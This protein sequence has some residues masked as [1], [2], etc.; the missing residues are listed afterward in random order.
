M[1]FV[2]E[3]KARTAQLMI[4]KDRVSASLKN[5][6]EVMNAD[7]SA[8]VE[9]RPKNRNLC[10]KVMLVDISLLTRDHQKSIENNID[11]SIPT[12]CAIRVAMN[13]EGTN[14]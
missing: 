2:T 13:L 12:E 11:K 1:Y 4:T 7:K 10:L 6:K 9:A 8:A 14:E 5:T 3:T